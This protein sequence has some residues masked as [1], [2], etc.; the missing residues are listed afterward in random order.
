MV[1]LAIASNFV[2]E[3]TEEQFAQ[4]QSGPRRRSA[5]RATHRSAAAATQ[6]PDATQQV[7]RPASAR[8]RRAAGVPAAKPARSTF[9]RL[10]SRLVQVRG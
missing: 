4:G 7:R 9:A 10:M 5:T 2:R 6:R 1:D 8:A 3:L